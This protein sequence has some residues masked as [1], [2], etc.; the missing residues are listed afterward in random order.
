M[1]DTFNDDQIRVIGQKPTMTPKKKR[2]LILIGVVLAIVLLVVILF[3]VLRQNDKTDEIA[4]N[5]ENQTVLQGNNDEPQ[6]Q[7]NEAAVTTSI[8]DGTNQKPITVSDTTVNGV[9]LRR[10]IPGNVSVE[11][12]MYDTT[13]VND[14]SIVFLTQAANVRG[15]NHNI[16]GDFVYKGKPK[17]EGAPKSAK[18]FCAIIGQTVVLGKDDTTTTPYLESTKK[19]NGYFFRQTIYVKGGEAMTFTDE[20]KSYRRAICSLNK[21]TNTLLVIESVDKVSMQEFAN[22]LSY[23][24]VVNAV[25][26]MGSFILDE[27]YRKD[28]SELVTLYTNNNPAHSNRNYLIFR[29]K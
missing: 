12:S 10:F 18:G 25:G 6:E 23:H 24:Q 15:D 3:L 29:K 11:L 13:L 8:I 14:S 26:L 28:N 16:I 5:T 1:T 21:K 9:K 19:Q 4:Q 20:A 7:V 27:W 17:A 22:A 2:T